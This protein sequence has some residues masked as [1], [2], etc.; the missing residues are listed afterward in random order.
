[1]NARFLLL[2]IALGL[3]DC[4]GR[5]SLP[6]FM[7][8]Q[9]ALR[10]LSDTGAGKI[11]HIVY[12]VQ[13]NR[14]FDNLFQGYPGADTVASGKDSKARPITLKPVGLKISYILVPDEAPI[15]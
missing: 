2:T 5:A 10:A 8:S 4:G 1:M 14:S 7:Q 15:F 13:E 3:G 11:T 9:T 12:I 6:P